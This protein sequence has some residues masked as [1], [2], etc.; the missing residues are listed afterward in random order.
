MRRLS[1][2]LTL[3]MAACLWAG[4]TQA[5]RLTDLRIIPL[6]QGMN[7]IASFTPDGHPG[8][9]TMAWRDNGNAHGYFLYLVVAA[10]AADDWHVVSTILDAGRVVDVLRDD[11]HAFEDAVTSLRF[12]HGKLDG[13]DATLLVRAQ[14]LW[15]DSIPAPAPVRFEA[16]RLEGDPGG[17]AGRTEY[18]FRKVMTWISA[19]RFC[20]A[21]RALAEELS[22]SIPSD[23]CE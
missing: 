23:A 17:D 16:F 10:V 8:R 2:V 18:Q 1:F 15:K 4:Q 6:R 11:P 9:I 12:L 19:K 3:F 22:L 7:E 5:G 13:V 21:D 14:R 20:N